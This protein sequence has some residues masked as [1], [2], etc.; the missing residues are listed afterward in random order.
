MPT[1]SSPSSASSRPC[2]TPAH[3]PATSRRC[4]SV[5]WVVDARPPFAGPAAVLAY[6][7]RY[8][9]RVAIA[10][11]RLIAFDERPRHLPLEG[12]PRQGT[13]ALQDDVARHRGVHPT[14]P[15]PRPAARLPPHPTLRM[16]ANARRRENL[17]NARRLLDANAPRRARRP[18]RREHRTTAVAALSRLRGAPARHRHRATPMAP[19]AAQPTRRRP[20]VTPT[21]STQNVMTRRAPCTTRHR[22]RARRRR[23][24]RSRA[25]PQSVATDTSTRIVPASHQPLV[26]SRAR[27]APHPST[28]PAR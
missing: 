7:S 18:R 1:A 25:N 8:T 24:Q 10:N 3:S 17:A 19:T 6:L 2:T 5:E 14:L 22:I 12:L 13:G 23:D 27:R 16:L 26:P 9:H 21:S 28:Q 20:A 15:H 11:S 4:A